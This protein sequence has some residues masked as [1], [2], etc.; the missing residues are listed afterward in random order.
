[1]M[2]YRSM[3]SQACSNHLTDEAAASCDQLLVVVS[4]GYSMWDDCDGQHSPLTSL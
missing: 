3:L 4:L 2:E 1:M